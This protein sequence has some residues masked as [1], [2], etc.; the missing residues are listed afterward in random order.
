MTPLPNIQRFF[1]FYH[2][3]SENLRNL[4]KSIFNKL[5]MNER[6]VLFLVL[7]LVLSG[8]VFADL[9]VSAPYV[10]GL[11]ESFTYSG[12]YTN[13]SGSAQANVNVTINVS[14]HVYT[15]LTD[16]T[17]AFSIPSNASNTTGNSTIYATSN[18]SSTSYTFIEYVTNVSNVTFTFNSTQTTFSTGSTFIINITLVNNASVAIASYLPSVY[19]YKANGERQLWTIRNLSGGTNSGGLIQYNISIPSTAV[20]IYFISVENGRGIQQISTKYDAVDFL[21]GSNNNG[22]VS[23]STFGQG[24]TVELFS[25]LTDD[26]STAISNATIQVYVKKPDGNYTNYTL[27]EQASNNLSGYYNSSFNNTSTIGTYEVETYTTVDGISQRR[28]FTFTVSPISISL[29]SDT[30]SEKMFE[31]G[32]FKGARPGSEASFFLV[33][34]NT[35]SGSMLNATSNGVN[36]HVNCSK[37]TLVDFVRTANS[38]SYRSVVSS[39]FS[40]T[41]VDTFYSGAQTCLVNFTSP[42]ITGVYRLTIRLEYSGT[43]YTANGYVPLQKYLLSVMPQQTTAGGGMGGFGEGMGGMGGGEMGP[44]GFMYKPGANITFKVLAYDVNGTQIT[45]VS[46]ISV[47]KLRN[48]PTATTFFSTNSS[49]P[50]SGYF[51][52]TADDTTDS[53]SI[54]LPENY[55]DMFLLDVQATNVSG[56]L[57]TGNGFVMAKWIMGFL[58]PQVSWSGGYGMGPSMGGG[59]IRCTNGVNFTGDIRLAETGETASGIV[60]RSIPTMLIQED[61]GQSVK[62]C[63][64][65]NTTQSTN[66][67]WNNINTTATFNTSCHSWGGEYFG[68]ANVTYTD[69]NGMSHSDGVPFFLKCS[70]IRGSVDIRGTSGN[71]K[72]GGLEGI[73]ITVTNAEY[74][75]GTSLSSGS[76]SVQSM[77]SFGQSFGPPEFLSPLTVL[78]TSVVNGSAN[79]LIYSSNFSKSTWADDDTYTDFRL[80]FCDTQ[81]VCDTMRRGVMVGGNKPAMWWDFWIVPGASWPTTI[82]PGTRLSLVFSIKSNVTETNNTNTQGTNITVTFESMGMG[83]SIKATHVNNSTKLSDNWNSSIDGNGELWMVNVTVPTGL[84]KGGVKIKLQVKDY[85]GTKVNSD[86]WTSV[87]GVRVVI[88]RL[89]LFTDTESTRITEAANNATLITKGWNMS[90]LTRSTAFSNLF[91]GYNPNSQVCARN[92]LS[93]NEAMGMGGSGGGYGGYS[94]GFTNISIKLLVYDSNGDAAYDRVVIRKMSSAGSDTNNTS[95]GTN[96]MYV[97]ANATL[98]NR[99]FGVH[100]LVLDAIKDCNFISMVNTTYVPSY[101]MDASSGGGMGGTWAGQETTGTSFTLPF[102]VRKG[103]TPVA[104]VTVNISGVFEE[105]YM[106]YGFGTPLAAT[107]WSVTPALTDAN[108]LAFVGLQVNRSGM[109]KFFWKINGS[110]NDSASFSDPVRMDIRAFQMFGMRLTTLGNNTVTLSNTSTPAPELFQANVTGFMGVSALTTISYNESAG[111]IN[112]TTG[113]LNWTCN[114]ASLC[115]LTTQINYGGLQYAVGLN[116]SPS[117]ATRRFTFFLEPTSGFAYGSQPL[118]Q[119]ENLYAALCLRD[120]AKP[121]S[122]KLTTNATVSGLVLKQYTMTGQLTTVVQSNHPLNGSAISSVPVGP[123]GCALLNISSSNWPTVNSTS[124]GGMLNLQ[125]TASVSVSGT[126]QSMTADLLPPFMVGSY[127]YW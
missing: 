15:G 79:L 1:P 61:T 74:T 33:V 54:Q 118:N 100:G 42:S 91:T 60:L 113:G 34:E 94:G 87:A 122:N 81:G 70:N 44:S 30:E 124:G 121:E 99:S 114:S 111:T 11:N 28:A 6:F 80:R 58:N 72:V 66:S 67:S 2:I 82:S 36:G 47:V 13:S 48:L 97:F 117:A 110:T 86:L 90:F 107:N 53:V 106:G 39:S 101:G 20:G 31:F 37:V 103:I 29:V 22:S 40:A 24:A 112:V 126:Q 76:L 98:A 41:N 27:S 84:A 73:N 55:S 125:G 120:F 21:I 115:A 93:F 9:S 25:K 38:T 63:F 14:G 64:T 32:G 59:D 43:N 10:G 123:Y 50:A 65:F 4:Y 96:A 105:S 3:S 108:G 57:A 19:I 95:V 5:N 8:F 119:T 104:G 71:W 75:N 18:G 89:N 102:L 35:S 78:N 83:N 88:A 52:A 26:N 109:Y 92:D 85:N 51:R 46:G 116:D 68:L 69:P 49:S 62:A 7:S 56:D 16:A 127:T 45:D 12:T 23:T 17:G 77:V